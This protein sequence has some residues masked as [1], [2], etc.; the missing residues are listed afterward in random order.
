MDNQPENEPT[1]TTEVSDEPAVIQAQP[2]VSAQPPKRGMS[3]V[4]I[5]VLILVLMAASGAAGYLLSGR[6]NDTSQ[7]SNQTQQSEDIDRPS[8]AE[9]DDASGA[10]IP[11]DFTQYKGDGFS[12]YYP[13][14]WGEAVANDT[15]NDAVLSV[16]FSQ[17]GKAS[18]YLNSGNQDFTNGGRGG[19]LWDCVGYA[20]IGDKQY[21]CLSVMINQQKDIRGA[22]LDSPEHIIGQDDSV[23][24]INDYTFFEVPVTQILFNPSSSKYYGGTLLISD[25]EEED[26]EIL[27][28]IATTFSTIAPD[29]L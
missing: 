7:T 5:A 3:K 13:E 19:A 20:F 26:K 1:Q 4:L 23:V 15:Q 6:E 12:F 14:E 21:A 10:E 29:G 22:I 11:A 9:N 8:V 25:S 18:L 17:N 16:T 2:V 24:L 28:Q 27:R